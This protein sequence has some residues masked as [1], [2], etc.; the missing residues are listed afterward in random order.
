VWIHGGAWSIGRK[1][2]T[3]PLDWLALGY[4][5]ASVDYRLSGD[6]VFP[7]QLHDVKAAVWA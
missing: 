6:A 3:V 1:E 5:V 7:A 2:D 4:A